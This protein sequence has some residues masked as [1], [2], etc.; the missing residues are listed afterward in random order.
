MIN[1]E[2]YGIIPA[3]MSIFKSDLT[4]DMEKT[5][6]HSENLLKSGSDFIVFF[7]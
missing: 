6:K 5:L 4:L 7:G 3:A 2:V 1:K